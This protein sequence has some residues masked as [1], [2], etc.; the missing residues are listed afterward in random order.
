MKNLIRISN[1]LKFQAIG[2]ANIKMKIPVTL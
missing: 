1:L 2:Q